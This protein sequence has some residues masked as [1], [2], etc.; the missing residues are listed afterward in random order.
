VLRA[1]KDG[2]HYPH[3]CCC[4]VP[5]INDDEDGRSPPAPAWKVEEEPLEMT[6][7][8]VLLRTGGGSMFCLVEPEL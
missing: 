1:D 4:D 3:L 6:W 5:A 8:S 2:R 7:Q